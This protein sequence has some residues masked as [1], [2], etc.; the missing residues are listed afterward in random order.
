M[1]NEPV[2]ELDHLKAD[3]AFMIRERD[4]AVERADEL[5]RLLRETGEL[6]K[7]RPAGTV[8]RGM[9]K[10]AIWQYSTDHQMLNVMADAVWD[11]L[12]PD[13]VDVL[14]DE[15][16]HAARDALSATVNLL[17]TTFGVPV[18]DVDDLLDEIDWR[19]VARNHLG[20]AS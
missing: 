15:F 18:L 16:E 3:L 8:T 12:Q 19:Q 20:G 6:E 10:G 11:L 14:A 7:V 17:L 9:I 1:T 5:A 4:A 13:P 2:S